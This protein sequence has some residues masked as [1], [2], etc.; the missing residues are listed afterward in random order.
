M[1]PK[2]ATTVRKRPKQERSQATVEAILTATTRILTECSQ[3]L[4][5]PYVEHIATSKIA[6]HTE[7]HQIC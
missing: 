4:L 3:C 6:N 5:S 7:I 1:L 2:P